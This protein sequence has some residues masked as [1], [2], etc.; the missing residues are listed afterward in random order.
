MTEE[1]GHIRRLREP[2]TTPGETGHAPPSLTPIGEAG[3]IR[4]LHEPVTTPG[5]TR[6]APPSLTPKGTVLH[7]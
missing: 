4:R 5:E 3:H 1:A 2:V 6:H 7:D